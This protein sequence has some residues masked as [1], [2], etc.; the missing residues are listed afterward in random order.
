MIGKELELLYLHTDREAVI[1]N[2]EALTLFRIRINNIL[3]QNIQVYRDLS[4]AKE[5]RIPLPQMSAG[6]YIISL[7]SEKGTLQKKIIIE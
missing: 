1:R 6:V 5:I 3:G 2:P 4:P 7:D